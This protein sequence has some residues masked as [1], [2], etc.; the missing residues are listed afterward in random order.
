MSPRTMMLIQVSIAVIGIFSLLSG[1]TGFGL[2][3]LLIAMAPSFVNRMNTGA[4]KRKQHHPTD[5]A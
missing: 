2:I 1:R 4:R 3:C 5:S